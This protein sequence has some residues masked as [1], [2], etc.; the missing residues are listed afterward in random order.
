MNGVALTL[1]GDLGADSA[2]PWIVHRARL[3]DLTGCVRRDSDTTIHMA[4]AGPAA[5]IDAME[6]ACSLGPGDVRVDTIQRGSHI[7]KSPPV[8]F[9]HTL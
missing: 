7:F 2:I 1:I 6:V 4:L 9:E 3:L 8:G 5:L